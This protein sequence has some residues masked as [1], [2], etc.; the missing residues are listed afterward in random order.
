MKTTLPK[1]FSKSFL[2][3]LTLTVVLSFTFLTVSAQ[4]QRYTDSWGNQGLSLKRQST[5]GI[6]LNFSIKEFN[7][8]DR[9]IN[10]STMKGIEF[11]ESLLQNEE[12]CPDLPGFGRY[13]AIPQGATPVVEIVNMRTERFT[14]V[15]IAPAPRI[16]LDTEDGPLYYEKKQTV[17]SKNELYPAQPV[18]IGD[19]SQIR[20][21]DVAMLGI[22]PYQ[23]N[24]ATKELIVYR[25]IEINIRFE[26]GNR[27]FGN[28]KYRNPY[29]DA[30]MEDAIFNY[31]SLPV[32]EYNTRS[33]NNRSTGWEYVI[34]T[35]NNEIFTQWADS[36]KKFRT[37]EGIYTGVV[38]LS[39]IGTNVNANML[40]AY[41]NDAYA[42]WD[43]PPVAVL[44]L[45]DYGSNNDDR[46][47]SPIW[48]NYCVSDNILADV[49]GNSMPDIVFARITAQNADQLESMI[50]RFMNYERHPPTNPSF[51]DKP[52]T[53]LGWQTERWFQICSEVVGGFWK[54]GLGK[55]P[56]RIN[57][58]Y[59]GSPGS[60]WSSAQ[61]TST[62][63]GIFG[64]A[65]LGYIPASPSELGNWS[66]GNASQ[67]NNAINEG[68]FM[69]MHR[70]HGYE[71]GWGEPSYGNSNI[72]G[73]TNTDLCFILSVNCLTGK[74]NY[75]SECFT[76]KFHRH[77]FL[78]QP[79]GALGLIA[80][81]EVS[82][83]FVNDVYVWGLT[84]NL[85]PGFMPQYG[86]TPNSRGVLPAFG[87]AA[88]KYFL[89]QSNWPY[90]TSNKEVT[91]NLFHHHGDAFLRVCAF[92]P[93][94]I[95]ATYEPELFEGDTIFTINATPNSTIALTVD[96]E[97]LGTGVTGFMS[98]IE[99]QIPPQTA[100]TRVKVVI[101][102]QNSNRYENWL[103]IVPKATSASAGE[104]VMICE[105]SEYQLNGTAYNYETL[106]WETSGTGTF[107][108]ATILNPVYTPSAN[109]F[110][111]SSVILSLT[112]FNPAVADSTDT[113]VLSFNPAPVVVAGENA[114]IC[115]GENFTLSEASVEN[116]TTMGWVTSGTGSFDD[117]TA[118]NP[119]YSP[120][121]EDLASGTVILTLSAS[122]DY[123]AIAEAQ[124]ELQI[125]A[126]P[127]P[128][129]QGA[130]TVCQYQSELI[131][132]AGT[133]ANEYQW[134][135][136]GGTIVNGQ[137][138]A[139]P[140]ITW[141][142]E[143]TGVITM[144]ET[145][146][147][148]CSNTTTYEVL[149]NAAPA[150]AIDGSAVV[151]ANSEQIVYTSPMVEGN[152]YEWLAEGGEIIAG[153]NTNEVSVN[154]GANGNGML[155]LIETSGITECAAMAEYNVLI[156]SPMISL[157][158]DTSICLTHVL[159]L[160]GE[161]GYASYLWSNGETSQSIQLIGEELG[162]GEL[163]YTLT[164]TNEQGCEGSASITVTVGACL[165]IDEPA[166]TGK[167]SI[168]PNPNN[169]E[170]TLEL[171]NAASGK[172]GISILNTQGE[173]VFNKSIV[174]NQSMHKENLHLNLSSGI[175]FVR[176]ES[177]QGIT[178]QKL[179]IK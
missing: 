63:V 28:E 174:I 146:E 49:S 46:I 144:T 53:A 110:S 70:D 67:I 136:M 98:D 14:N 81:S 61:N 173:V 25:D 73:L 156:D 177:N 38:K 128:M 150:P 112:A 23:Y 155:T 115:A 1:F 44:I 6:G 149:V 131:Y 64:P 157:G 154:W 71:G 41:V 97:I 11:S 164:V 129:I 32:I 162:T 169:G 139:S 132:T 79:A 80:A 88:G 137:N 135:I 37:E 47:T 125:N 151:C 122:N 77:T 51:Y 9:N 140:A 85:W 176:I 121:V 168:L 22:T 65:G 31:S 15:E 165:G 105:G 141:D 4:V 163:P 58:I 96:G 39:D 59:Q 74:Y 78:G 145:N 119:V 27:Q 142:E 152:T 42:N 109:D 104:D 87:N 161:N 120:S 91:Y 54:N 16:P 133:V 175:Y 7:F 36:I 108:D 56:V 60:I 134:D 57:E 34:I 10:G 153:A 117:P 99:I 166:A 111:M 72:N 35:P 103:D 33:R 147:F 130:D 159:N 124:I 113:M 102:R 24:P 8:V 13:I 126:L 76:E 40:E 66:G 86:A 90:N 29:W 52:I 12:G 94:D 17:Y 172:T 143:G 101:T 114:N 171:N 138:S 84:D 118:V 68:S 158:A 30:I 100:G 89:K 170:F 21:V 167:F 75:S 93:T 43:I 107:D 82:Y 179:V 116:Q 19:F 95:V 5:D 106:L 2:S 18:T 123:C 62:V 127:E 45:G 160:S 26:G 48:D 69:L 83:S 178:I 55:N 148:G 3:A 50:G 92:V 20:G